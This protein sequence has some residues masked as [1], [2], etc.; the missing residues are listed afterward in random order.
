MNIP[1]TT[2]FNGKDRYGPPPNMR[3]WRVAAYNAMN[4]VSHTL[5]PMRFKRY[6][7]SKDDFLTIENQPVEKTVPTIVQ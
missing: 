7:T 6:L 2:I 5:F 1:A 4:T 3:S